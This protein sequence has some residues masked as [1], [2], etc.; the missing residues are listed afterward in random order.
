MA[1]ETGSLNRIEK[2]AKWEADVRPIAME[3][4][5]LAGQIS[6]LA[7]AVE[8]VSLRDPKPGGPESGECE[9]QEL[10]PLF[11]RIRRH[12]Y[13]LQVLNDRLAEIIEGIRL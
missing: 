6:A 13:Q 12:S 7:L 8:P 4:D 2:D 11:D 10:P 5:R 3:L 9:E 1:H